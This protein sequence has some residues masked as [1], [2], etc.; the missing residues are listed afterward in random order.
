MKDKT[1]DVYTANSSGMT[2]DDLHRFIER[3]FPQM[4]RAGFEITRLDPHGLTVSLETGDRHLRPGG[5]IS[6]PTLMTM[7]DTG[8]YLLIMARLG[9]MALAVTSNLEIH[10]LR[11]PRPGLLHADCRV[12]KLGRRNAVL[13][14]DLRSDQIAGS[15][16][17][18]TVTYAL[19][20]SS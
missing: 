9:P 16:A 14:V 17:V 11:K 8:A 5:T 12:L 6:G 4:L 10:F 20:S 15:V 13:A 19:P 3:E 18:A 2:V 1:M 7:A